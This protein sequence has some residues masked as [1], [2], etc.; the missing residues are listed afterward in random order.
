MAVVNGR[1]ERN[2]LTCDVSVG[3]LLMGGAL[4]SQQ[5]EFWPD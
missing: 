5:V 2:T 1:K 3:V 4:Q